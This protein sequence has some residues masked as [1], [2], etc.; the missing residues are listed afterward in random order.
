[1]HL[2]LSQFTRLRE[3]AWESAT[4][5]TIGGFKSAVMLKREAYLSRCIPA[6]AVERVLLS[7]RIQAGIPFILSLGEGLCCEGAPP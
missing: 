7:W 6:G 2:L 5:S 1:M 3:L 4:P